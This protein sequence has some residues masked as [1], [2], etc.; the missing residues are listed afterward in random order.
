MPGDLLT[1]RPVRPASEFEWEDLLVRLELM[2]RVLRIALE[3][4]RL[5]GQDTAEVLRA[6]VEREERVRDFLEGAAGVGPEP[7][8]RDGIQVVS[9]KE[10]T[11][12]RFVR[13]RTRN[14]AMVQRRG[15][16]VWNW[17]GRLGDE[18]VSIYQ[19]LGNLAH[20]DVGTLAALRGAVR[21]GASAC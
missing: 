8:P 13:I 14:F 1:R 21:A 5:A 3:S 11:L 20:E 12:E 19:V 4:G 9:T 6:L 10:D 7:R 18:D 15:I 16:E 2:P 17:H